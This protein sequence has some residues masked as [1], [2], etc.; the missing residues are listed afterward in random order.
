[1]QDGV[2]RQGRCGRDHARTLGVEGA[3]SARHPS[4]RSGLLQSRPGGRGQ[5]TQAPSIW[6]EAM[7]DLIPL[8]LPHC[9]VSPMGIQFQASLS[10]DDWDQVGASLQRVNGALQWW[11]GD[12]I[13][14]GENHF[15][16]A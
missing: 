14:W 10:F 16:T 9:Q 13:V 7:K 11:I 15:D 2:R 3:H 8:K 5:E 1:M 12:W 6:A 4:G